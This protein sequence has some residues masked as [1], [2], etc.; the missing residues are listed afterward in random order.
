MHL[1]ARNLNYAYLP[2]KTVLHDVSLSLKAGET[3]YILGRNGGGKTTLLSCLAGL[4]KPHKGSVSINE[5]D[6]HD[7]NDSQRAQ[8]IGLIPQMHV[9]VFT[10]SVE[11]M[12][13][14]GRAPYLNW[15]GSPSFEDHR[16]V[17]EALEQVGIS[18]LRHR[19][20]TEI[21]GGERQLTMIARGL[22]QKCQVLMMDE[23]TAHLDLSNQQRVLEIVQQLTTQSLSFIISSHAPNDALAFADRVLLLNEGWEMDYGAPKDVLTE[24]MLSSVYG[25]QA[26]VI[27][28]QDNGFRIPRAVVPR[29]PANVSPDSLKQPGG[30]LAKLFE[31]RHQSPQLLLVTGLSG[32]GK[33][34]WCS[35]LTKL[36]KQSGFS[37]EGI[38]SPGIFENGKKVGIS[39]R[40][41][42][43]GEEQQLAKIREKENA[44]LT[45]P[46]WSFFPDALEW[47]NQTL[48]NDGPKDLLVIDELGPLEFLRG[49]GLTVG[50][51]RIDTGQYQVACVVVRSS[52]LP[53]AL[54]RWPHAKVINGRLDSV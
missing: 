32:A 23:P 24:A 26:E 42:I 1:Q 17:E 6:L 29:R 20:Y 2:G 18:D 43:T 33:T 47:A 7:Y 54:Q 45:T 25:I 44:N 38:L 50:L 5:R 41:L 14:M 3:L 15:M 22:A 49:E 21:S 53:K 27:Y 8:L 13:M 35:K 48:K 34:T 52:L 31:E 19:P 51:M 30:F 28:V 46:R 37:V 12:V 16:I 4:L 36:A 11:E 10:Y 39:V 40:S 9:P